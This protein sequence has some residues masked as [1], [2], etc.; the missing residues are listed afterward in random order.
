NN[1]H[2]HAHVCYEQAHTDM[3]CG[4]T[5]HHTHTTKQKH[6]DTQTA[7]TYTDRHTQTNSHTHI[8]SYEHMHRDIYTPT[9]TQG[10][11]HTH[12]WFAHTRTF[13]SISTCPSSPQTTK[14]TS[15][16]RYVFVCVFV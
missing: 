10:H 6:D 7:H 15:K 12:H 11:I 2:T 5:Y 4:H 8:H 13:T 1:R 9:H 16:Q 3:H 14:T